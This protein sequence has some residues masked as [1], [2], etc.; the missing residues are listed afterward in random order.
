MCTGLTCVGCRLQLLNHL[1]AGR[2][3]LLSV[4]QLVTSDICLA[5]PLTGCFA[6]CRLFLSCKRAVAGKD[7]SLH[8]LYQ[9]V[10][11]LG[12]VIAVTADNKWPVSGGSQTALLCHGDARHMCLLA[13]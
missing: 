1:T 3:W 9:Q 8:A 11:G 2:Q 12:G 13:L 4:K 10:T 5:P 7:L 6:V